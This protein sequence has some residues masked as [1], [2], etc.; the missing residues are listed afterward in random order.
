ME[1]SLSLSG[2]GFRAT[3]YHLGVLHYQNRLVLNDGKK[4]L[5]EV[6]VISG[7]PGGALTALW[8][9]KNEVKDRSR[10]IVFRELYHLLDE[11]NIAQE[12]LD[13]NFKEDSPKYQFTQLLS[14]AYD[15]HFF[16][17]EL[18]GELTPNLA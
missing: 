9:L 15:K 2:G 7:I 4:L 12:I 11:T 3:A 14:E 16:K 5:D 8:Y 17:G 6:N 18:F 1:I 10:D 13:N